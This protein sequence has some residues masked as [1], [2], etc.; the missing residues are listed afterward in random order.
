MAYAKLKK[1]TLINQIKCLG[2]FTKIAYDKK[3]SLILLNYPV[4]L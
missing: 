4:I 2:V 1:K 3:K